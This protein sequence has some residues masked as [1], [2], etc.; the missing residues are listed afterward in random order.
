[1][2]W[3]AKVIVSVLMLDL[4]IITFES[5]CKEAFFE[6]APGQVIECHLL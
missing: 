3:L 6:V 5:I 1:V 2:G 4:S